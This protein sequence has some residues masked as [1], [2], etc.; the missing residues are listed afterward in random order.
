MGLGGFLIALLLLGIALVLLFY[1][2]WQLM[3]P[4]LV[5][6]RGRKGPSQIRKAAG[7]LQKVDQLISEGNPSEALKI[8]RKSFLLDGETSSQQNLSRL[9]EHHQNVLSRALVLAEEL[10]G[11]ADNIAEVEHALMARIELQNLHLKATESYQN[12][13]FRRKQAGKEL[14]SWSRSDF[15]ARIKEIKEELKKNESIVLEQISELF[16]S[17][18]SSTEDDDSIIYH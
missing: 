17:L 2:S 7:R 1:F 15:E 4:L 16:A 5:G 13:K 12:V 8:L 10:N 9:K 18:Q 3:G 14:P 11:R 6:L